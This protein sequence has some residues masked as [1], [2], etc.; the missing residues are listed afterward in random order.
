MKNEEKWQKIIAEKDA[1]IASLEALIKYYEEQF[2]LSKIRQFGSLSE[3]GALTEQYCLFDEVENTANPQEPEPELEEIT[4]TRRKRVGKRE[5]DLS[6]LPIEVVKHKLPEEEQICSICGGALHEMGHD[7]RR[8]L[9]IIPAQV[10]VIEHERTVYSC[11]NCEKTGDHVEIVKAPTPLP[12]I[13]GSLASPSAVAHIMTQKYVMC[14]PLY[15][16]EKDWE[17]QGLFLSRQTMA[18]WVIRCSEDWLEPL[19]ERM[20]EI[21]LKSRVLHSDETRIQVLKEPGRAPTTNSFMW[22]YRTS[23]DTDRHI[24]LFEYQ[25]TRSASHPKLFLDGFTGILHTDGYAGY[26]TLSDITVIGCWVHARRK[27]ADA[28]KV[29]PES[30][31]ISSTAQEALK[32]IG[33]LFHLEGKW[34]NLNPDERY[35]QRIEES[36]PIAEK[37]FEWLATLMVLPKS[38]MGKAVGYALEQRQWM[39]NVYIDGRA[40][41]SNNRAEN[42][43]RPFTLGRKNWL[44]CNTVKGAKASAVVYSIIETAKEN[45]L[46]PYEYLKFL[47]KTI[48]NIVSRAELDSLLPWGEAVPECCRMQKKEGAN[49]K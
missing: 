9:E 23:G 32:S 29:I 2:K 13:K 3:K 19:Y 14:S 17:R 46:K 21:L 37:F 8:E 34:E 36:K 11:R 20:H 28:L 10:K 41:I 22:L 7:T 15:R 39:M 31:R 45:S 5:D 30:E 26:H 40:E 38:A 27:F 44:F 4:Y 43:V 25:P 16:Q 35:R 48:P 12:V 18:N 24:V 1:R 42:A 33:Y 6:N 47:L 49:A